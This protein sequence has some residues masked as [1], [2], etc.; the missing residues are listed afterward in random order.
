MTAEKQRV[1]KEMGTRNE[2]LIEKLDK[3]AEEKE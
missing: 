1:E 3:M 2:A